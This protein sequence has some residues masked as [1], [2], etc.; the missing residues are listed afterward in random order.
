MNNKL[1]IC[2]VKATIE[3][4]ILY[5]SQCLTLDSTLITRIDGCY[6]RLLRM[7]QN[8]SWKSKTS[9]VINMD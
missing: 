4:V 1:K 9:N 3:T 8:I 6:T 7:A 5:D 2:A